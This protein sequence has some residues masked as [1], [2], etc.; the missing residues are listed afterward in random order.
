MLIFR[1]KSL[2]FHQSIHSKKKWDV[3]SKICKYFNYLS[4]TLIK[5]VLFLKEGKESRKVSQK[6]SKHLHI[7]TERKW[8]KKEKG[9]VKK[10]KGKFSHKYLYR[11]F[12]RRG[13]V[14]R[15]WVGFGWLGWVKHEGGGVSIKLK[16]IRWRATP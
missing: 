13:F 4:F 7:E 16:K 12:T 3:F 14:K 10:E 6:K 15:F 1:L 9:G 8:E 5:S 2:P 11:E